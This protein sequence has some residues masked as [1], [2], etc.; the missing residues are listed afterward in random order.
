MSRVEVNISIYDDIDF[1]LSKTSFI[2]RYGLKKF[3]NDII[4]KYSEESLEMQFVNNITGYFFP[5][6]SRNLNKL[7][8]EIRE[9]IKRDNLSNYIMVE[10]IPIL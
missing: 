5:V 7:I 10:T 8:K 6:D 2:D 4:D 3:I 9:K 1:I